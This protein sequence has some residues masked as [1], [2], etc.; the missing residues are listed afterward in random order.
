MQNSSFSTSA[1]SH[2]P[3]IGKRR[4]S[5]LKQR[6]SLHIQKILDDT[7]KEAESYDKDSAKKTKVYRDLN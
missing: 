5:D 1:E 6:L 7:K 4:L 3:E 2:S